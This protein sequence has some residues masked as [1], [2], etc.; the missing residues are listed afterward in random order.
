[1]T[2]AFKS[3]LSE[4][5][6]KQQRV[7]NIIDGQNLILFFTKD[8]GVFGA[9][10]ESRLVFAKLKIPDDETPTGWEDDASFAAFDLLKALG[11]ER[12]QNLFSK[13]DLGKIKVVDK[14]KAEEI[15]MKSPVHKM[16]QA[17]TDALKIRHGKQ[18]A[19]MI[20]LKDKK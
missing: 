5:E 8:N 10:E 13:K 9:P 17:I 15:L 3:W 20:K 16:T 19:G 18:G 12:V 11:G 6:A 7:R 14:D 4:E 2:L 1:M